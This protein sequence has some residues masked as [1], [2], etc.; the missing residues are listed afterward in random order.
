[1]SQQVL[2]FSNDTIQTMKQYY[3][4]A[5]IDIPQGAVFR[6]K[7]NFAVI[8]AYRSGKVLFQ[9]SAPEKEVEKWDKSA[10]T[11]IP[12]SNRGNI[13]VQRQNQH[14]IHHHHI[15]SVVP[16]SVLMKRARVITLDPLQ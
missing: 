13:K 4:H 15:S 10:S 16:I 7:T 3:H 9:G 12:S 5:L 2:V 14:I 1:M 11:S 6:A 8:T